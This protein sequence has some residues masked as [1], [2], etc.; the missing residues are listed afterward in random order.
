L[1]GLPET[2]TF[3]EGETEKPFEVTAPPATDM[4]SYQIEASVNSDSGHAIVSA[5]AALVVNA[6]EITDLELSEKLA[7]KFA[8]DEVCSDDTPMV[9]VTLSCPAPPEGLAVTLQS[10]TSSA[11]QISLPPAVK[12]EAGKTSATFSI[13]PGFYNSK[14]S[15]EKVTIIA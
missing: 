12:V 5:A 13:T 8:D 9:T 4:V 10:Q 11:L 3:E 14:F 15:D 7:N 1:K 6:P 2:L